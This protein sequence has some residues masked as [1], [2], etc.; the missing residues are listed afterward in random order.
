MKD[1]FIWTDIGTN[2]DDLL[3]VL[4]AV[5]SPD[6]RVLGFATC[7]DPTGLRARFLSR[8][9]AAEGLDIAVGVGKK[10]SQPAT[11][12]RPFLGP[13][14]TALFSLPDAMSL[15]S[16][17]V[18]SREPV[19]VV[20]LGPLGEFAGCL[21]RNPDLQERISILTAMGGSMDGEDEYNFSSNIEAARWV[22]RSRLRKRV[23]PVDLTR[24]F[25]LREQDIERIRLPGGF[26]NEIVREWKRWRTW[27]GRDHLFLNDPLALS[28]VLG[29]ESFSFKAASSLSSGI[30]SGS[31]SVEIASGVDR[32]AFF[33]T[34]FGLLE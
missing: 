26:E 20:S 25:Y 13:E 15:F 7:D 24:Q 30:Y 31:T 21:I 4:M 9:L 10:S 1:I 29:L 34:F 19:E 33:E 3:A 18:C 23:I 8:L 22:M 12:E 28:C 6:V 17:I 5:R 16:G 11:P 27:S 2:P 32:G 14:E